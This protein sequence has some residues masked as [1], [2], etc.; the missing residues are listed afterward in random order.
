MKSKIFKVG[1]LKVAL[2]VLLG[3]AL[4]VRLVAVAPLVE[5]PCPERDATIS[6]L[7]AANGWVLRDLRFSTP[8]AGAGRADPAASP[9][10]ATILAGGLLLL[11]FG[12]STLKLWRAN[13][14]A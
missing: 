1:I 3:T 4:G 6:T 13:R 12:L 5:E 14:A 2:G 7:S 8:T 11:P 10:F 9:S